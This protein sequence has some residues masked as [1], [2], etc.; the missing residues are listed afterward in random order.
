M[1]RPGLRLIIDVRFGFRNVLRSSRFAKRRSSPSR[2]RNAEDLRPPSSTAQPTEMR[3]PARSS[4]MDGI[5]ADQA[6]FDGVV[7][8]VE[9]IIAV[10]GDMQSRSLSTSTTR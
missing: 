7:A 3:S 9:N 6:S 4:I 8:T 2:I 10:A 1:L 5:L